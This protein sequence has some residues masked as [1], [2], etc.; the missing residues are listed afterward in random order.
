MVRAGQRIVI[1]ELSLGNPRT[2]DVGA[3]GH[4]LPEDRP[5]ELTAVLASW[6]GDA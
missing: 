3:A 5:A 4:F 6:L 1:R 2:A